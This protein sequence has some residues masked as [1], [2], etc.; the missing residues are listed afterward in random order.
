[1][2]EADMKNRVIWVCS[3]FSIILL[4]SLLVLQLEAFAQRSDP[5]MGTADF[6]KYRI[7]I[8]QQTAGT[9]RELAAQPLPAQLSDKEKREAERYTKWLKDCSQ[10]LDELANRWHSSLTNMEKNPGPISKQNQMMEMNQSFNL[11]YLA[12][13]QAMQDENRQFSLVSNIMK[14]KHDTAKNSIN[15]IR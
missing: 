2:K 15:N 14:N 6:A 7:K 13:Q 10:K 1:M 9:L 5:S 8:L 3:L 11:Q 12:L 4:M